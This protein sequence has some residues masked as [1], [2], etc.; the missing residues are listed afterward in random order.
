MKEKIIKISEWILLICLL[1]IFTFIVF[2]RM[3]LGRLNEDIGEKLE[4]IKQINGAPKGEFE[5][6][7]EDEGIVIQKYL[8]SRSVVVIPSKIEGLPVIRL[9]DNMFYGPKAKWIVSMML[10]RYIET[11]DKNL[12]APCPKLKEINVSNQNK[13]YKSIHGVLLNKDQTI[14]ITYPA[15]NTR[16]RYKIPAKVK[17]I[18]E[19]AFKECKYLKDIVLPEGLVALEDGAF[20]G[21]DFLKELKLPISLVEIGDNAFYQ[22]DQLENIEVAEGN[23]VYKSV[24]GVLFD[25]GMTTLYKYP[26]LK[27][28]SSYTVPESVK[29]LKEYAF[30]GV[31]N[32][33]RITLPEGLEEIGECAFIGNKKIA[34]INLPKSLRYIYA[35]AFDWTGITSINI[36]QN[37]TQVDYRSFE[38]DE[39]LQ[40]IEVD[41][42]N[43]VYKSIDGV[44]FNK[45]GTV[46]IA[47]PAGKKQTIYEVPEKTN[48]IG[49]CAFMEGNTL[50][51]ITLPK[52]VMYI[53]DFS[54]SKCKSLEQITVNGRIMEMG[55]IVFANPDKLTVYCREDNELLKYYQPKLQIVYKSNEGNAAK[56]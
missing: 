19:N 32:L 28:N 6:T 35:G 45:A 49:A 18:G 46:L 36:P 17:I 15:A 56:Q 52:S 41:K 40:S 42:E 24:D 48:V 20:Q 55:S 21:C 38:S 1:F 39:N 23:R 25:C 10:P 2:Y 33:E 14:L 37:V 30:G 31:S 7:K 44:L 27:D 26:T 16:S 22:C 8:G 29:I 12:F 5:Y 47:Y 51:S 13:Y 9:S 54:L 50:E 11:I 3:D 53:E 43:K 34:S 4:V